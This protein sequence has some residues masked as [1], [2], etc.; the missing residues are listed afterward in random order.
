MYKTE[1][2]LSPSDDNHSMMQSG[3]LRLAVDNLCNMAEQVSRI[4]YAPVIS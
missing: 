2:Q 3:I 4:V 1:C